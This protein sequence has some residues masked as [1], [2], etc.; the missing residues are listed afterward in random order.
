MTKDWDDRWI[1]NGKHVNQEHFPEISQPSDLGSETIKEFMDAKSKEISD[2]AEKLKET[3][4]EEKVIESDKKLGDEACKA[5]KKLI[6]R[7]IPYVLFFINENNDFLFIY[8]NVVGKA[9]DKD[10]L[11]CDKYRGLGGMFVVMDHSAV[12]DENVSNILTTLSDKFSI[13]IIHNHQ[14]KQLMHNIRKAAISQVINRN[15]SHNIG[16]H[17]LSRLTTKEQPKKYEPDEENI[18]ALQANLN[19]YLQH[20]MEFIADLATTANAIMLRGNLKEIINKFFSYKLLIVNITGNERKVDKAAIPS[21]S[22]E[23]AIVNGILGE[24]AM[25]TILENLIRNSAK[26]RKDRPRILHIYDQLDCRW[27]DIIEHIYD[28]KSASEFKSVPYHREETSYEEINDVISTREPELILLDLKLENGSGAEMLKKIKGKYDI[29]VI[30]TT[31]S[32]EQGN[33]PEL[34][35][36]GA[37]DCWTKE[38]DRQNI[39]ALVKIIRRFQDNQGNK[40]VL[41]NVELSEDPAWPTY[42]KLTIYDGNDVIEDDKVRKDLRDGMDS[43]INRP[44]L[45]GGELRQEKWGVLEMK[46]AAAYL[47]KIPFEEVDNEPERRDGKP[48]QLKIDG[49]PVPLILECVDMKEKNAIAYKMYIPKPEEC[50]VVCNLSDEYLNDDKGKNKLSELLNCGIKII[51]IDELE[52]S[53]EYFDYEIVC[54][55]Q[56]IAEKV[57][58]EVRR[59]LPNRFLVLSNGKLETE[60]NKL[61]NNEI[62]P[63]KF[64]DFV[65]ESWLDELIENRELKPIKLS[66]FDAD[67]IE[68]VGRKECEI[69]YK[70]PGA[71]CNH[72]QVA[73]VTHG[74][75][76]SEDTVNKYEY[77][78][79]AIGS[80]N[81]TKILIDKIATKPGEEKVNK[82]FR[83]R[84]MFLE[85]IN[86]KV[87]I[88][89]ERI[90]EAAYNDDSNI[91]YYMCKCGIQVTPMKEDGKNINLSDPSFEAGALEK[92][93]QDRGRENG[94]VV[95]HIGIIENMIKNQQSGSNEKIDDKR[96]QVKEYIEGLKTPEF[97]AEIIIISGRGR[98]DSL[99]TGEKFLQYSNVQAAVMKEGASKLQLV[100]LLISA[101]Y[102]KL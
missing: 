68:G 81:L 36:L 7:F 57:K 99:P 52:K 100:Q 91:L 88:V 18:I 13:R 61:I 31:T 66:S 86:Y 48:A 17:V 12:D 70:E 80:Q 87:A 11:L 77:Y 75:K 85:A 41:I 40:G 22:K 3:L 34:K 6:N 58:V 27:S 54:T 89:D 62:T 5:L 98:P 69:P 2:Y 43:Y 82:E 96:K 83:L 24:H 4:E 67:N 39:N 78:F 47:R 38:Y 56:E 16:S 19:E 45:K 53:T 95:I 65:W 46:I 93:I 64:K 26:H 42:W 30:I 9:P 28:S 10:I 35:K 59:R 23:L 101:K 92:W 60:V 84:S 29:P 72:K 63:D 14:T 76:A 49:K 94:F 20:R 74:T 21:T 8:S 25:Y 97:K 79:E 32:N 50:L 15:M 1:R 90:Q 71:D 102:A 51:D 44:V 37:D 73:I 55:D 33:Y